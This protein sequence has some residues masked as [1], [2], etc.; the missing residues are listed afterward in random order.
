MA[1][2]ARKPK[3]GDKDK[4][5]GKAKGAMPGRNGAEKKPGAAKPEDWKN[6]VPG[7]QG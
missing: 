6:N 4:N 1:Q 3:N 2:D 7:D 5:K